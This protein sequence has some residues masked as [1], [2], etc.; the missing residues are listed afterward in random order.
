VEALTRENPPELQIADL[1][2]PCSNVAAM[3]AAQDLLVS[4]SM[5]R[6]LTPGFF[7]LEEM[8]T[9]EVLLMQLI[10]GEYPW[11]SKLDIGGKNSLCPINQEEWSLPG[12][13]GCTGTNGPHDGLEVV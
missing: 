6:C 4:C 8:I 1:Q 9:N 3:V 10:E 2:S 7:K 12:R 5:K 11:R 13:L